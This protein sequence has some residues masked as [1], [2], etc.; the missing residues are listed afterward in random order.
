VREAGTILYRKSG[1]ISE[2]VTLKSMRFVCFVLFFF[3][4]PFSFLPDHD[5]PF[6]NP[7][8]VFADTIKTVTIWTFLSNL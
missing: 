2:K 4:S 7:H 1:E 8:A 3:E 5:N 6:L